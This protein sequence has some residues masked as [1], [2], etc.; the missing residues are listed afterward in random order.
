MSIFDV[1]EDTFDV[2]VSDEQHDSIWPAE[3]EI[4]AGWRAVGKTG[5]TAE[6]LAHIE[7]LWFD[8]RPL[9]LRKRIDVAGRGATGPEWHSGI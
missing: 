1:E 5:T 2:V 3:R 7:K 9:S 6:C 4:P 8:T